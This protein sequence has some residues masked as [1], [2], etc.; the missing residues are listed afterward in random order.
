MRVRPRAKAVSESLLNWNGRSWSRVA[1]SLPTAETGYVTQDG[2][3]GLWLADIASRRSGAWFLDH[4]QSDRTWTR[5]GRIRPSSTAPSA[6]TRTSLCRE[7]IELAIMSAGTAPSGAHRQ[8][9][10]FVAVSDPS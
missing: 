5:Q 8:P 10:T 9:W 7:L 2:H 4:L 3:G 6:T 1:F